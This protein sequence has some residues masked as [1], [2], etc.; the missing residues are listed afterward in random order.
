MPDD[1]GVAAILA[2]IPAAG[3]RNAGILGAAKSDRT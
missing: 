3:K 2:I 1:P